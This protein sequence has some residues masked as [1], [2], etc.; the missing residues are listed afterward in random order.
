MFQCE[1]L[2]FK[3]NVRAISKWRYRIFPEH[4]G[5]STMKKIM[6]HFISHFLTTQHLTKMPFFNKPFLK[7]SHFI[8][9]TFDQ[10]AFFQQAIFKNKSFYQHTIPINMSF[11]QHVISSTCH[12]INMSLHQHVISSTCHFIN[13]SFH[14]HVI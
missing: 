12:Y 7:I 2:R 3:K 8:N 14:K 13:M 5:A 4:R 9:T 11:H 1:I 6:W 10:N